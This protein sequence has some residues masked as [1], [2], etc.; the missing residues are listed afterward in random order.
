MP[1]QDRKGGA[2]KIKNGPVTCNNKKKFM[3]MEEITLLLE[4]HELFV[5]TPKAE[6]MLN[7][8]TSVGPRL[9]IYDNL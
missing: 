3:H 4:T 5:F 9:P 2:N 1:A 6:Q 7:N 8:L